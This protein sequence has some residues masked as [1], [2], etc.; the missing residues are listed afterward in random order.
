M[1][2]GMAQLLQPD[3][4]FSGTEDS[5]CLQEV[6]F[7]LIMFY[8]V[9]CIVQVKSTRSKPIFLWLLLLLFISVC[10]C[11][12]SSAVPKYNR[13]G[14]CLPAVLLI[15][16]NLEQELVPSEGPMEGEVAA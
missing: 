9:F 15:T 2:A 10:V 14:M 5:D 13:K 11:V 7:S 12:I 1:S 4:G 6:V 16:L 3:T 8:V